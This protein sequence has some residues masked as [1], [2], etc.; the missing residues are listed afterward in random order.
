MEIEEMTREQLVELAKKHKVKGYAK[1]SL[2]QL[3]A[4]LVGCEPEDDEEPEEME[5]EEVEGEESEDEEVEEAPKPAKK[6]AKKPA[7][8]AKRGRAAAEPIARF[9]A[10]EQ[11]GVRPPTV[12]GSMVANIWCYLQDDLERNKAPMALA[13][14]K[15]ALGKA[16]YNV[17]TVTVQYTKWKRWNGLTKSAAK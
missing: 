1:M 5:D 7:A 14:A 6:S 4:A 15:E 13:D 17:T 2:A 8:A 12:E 10:G 3:R 16:G 11:N 9:S